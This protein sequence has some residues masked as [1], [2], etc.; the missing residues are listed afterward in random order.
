MIT[1]DTNAPVTDTDRVVLS[2]L[3]ERHDVAACPSCGKKWSVS[4]Q[5][6]GTKTIN[7]LR[8]W[9]DGVVVK[10]R[11]DYFDGTTRPI[12]DCPYP[13]KPGSEMCLGGIAEEGE[14]DFGNPTVYDEMYGA[15]VAPLSQRVEAKDLASEDEDI[16]PDKPGDDYFDGEEPRVPDAEF[17]ADDLIGH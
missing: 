7:H 15:V 17:S 12:E 3:R 4:I 8:F 5:P 13:T 14:L 2:E 1:F 9:Q 10:Q 16:L 6:I 11:P